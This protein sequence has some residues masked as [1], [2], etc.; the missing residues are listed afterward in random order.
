MIILKHNP[1]IFNG[2]STN[3]SK[4]NIIRLTYKNKKSD[5]R[6]LESKG[7]FTLTKIHL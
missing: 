6:K 2:M 5:V 3:K 4:S 7:I 1:G